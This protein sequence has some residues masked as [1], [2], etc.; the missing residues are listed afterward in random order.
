MALRLILLSRAYC[1][2]CDE[3]ETAVRPLAGCALLEVI[4]IDAPE[5]AAL[6][7]AFGDLVPVLFRDVAVAANEICRYRLDRDKL[8]RALAR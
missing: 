5:H 6:E 7:A 2:L 4:D 3:M 1:H 8:E